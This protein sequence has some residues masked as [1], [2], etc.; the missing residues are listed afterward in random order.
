MGSAAAWHLARRG[1]RVLG[2]EQFTPAH[3]LGSSHG[4]TRIVR[5][6]YF[7]A[8]DYVP[9][10]RRAYELWD[11]L[12]RQVGSE[13]FVRTGALM[14]G[15]AA[16]DVVAG[17]L[18]S[19]ARWQLPHERLDRAEIARRYP[20]FALEPGQEAVFERDAGYVDPQAAVRA[21]LQLAE[22]DGAELRFETP[23]LGWDYDGD[24]V[25]VKTDGADFR[26]HRLIIAAGAWAQRLTPGLDVSLRVGR[27]V[28][29]YLQPLT[30]VENF[31]TDRFPV[32]VY[33]IAPG[34]A[35]YGFPW[36]DDP[37][38]GVKIGF[39]YRGDDVD[40][41]DIERT[42]SAEEEEEL[43]AVLV[44]RIPSLAGPHVRSVVCMYTLTADEHFVIDHL[45]GADGR[46]VVAA[47]FSGH[48]F[49]FTP[50]VGEILADLALLGR[51]GLPIEF[52][53]AGRF[54]T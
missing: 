25:L 46:V 47:G 16:A 26:A 37:G 24:E 40:A 10:L 22:R 4:D 36:V 18:A 43:R 34:D 12:G 29:H 8:P 32:F 38:S 5:M 11:E 45:P 19:A 3:D 50:V 42:V 28:M 44:E 53:S 33:Q 13:L 14:I 9:L 48:G 2:L 35:I 20:Q 31:A 21:H 15:D 52:L 49:K 39:H 7:E 17:T 6:A 54:R 41:D 1:V 27:R 23:V 51:S 30:A